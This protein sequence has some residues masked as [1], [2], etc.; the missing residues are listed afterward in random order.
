MSKK[1][2]ISDWRYI[3][4]DTSFIIDYL[5]DPDKLNLNPVKKENCI[6]AKKIMDFISSNKNRPTFYVSSIT[7][8]ELKRLETQ[9]IA[10]KIINCFSAGDVTI[11]P[12][13]KMEAEILS[14]TVF[15]WKKQKQ[16]NVTL[17]QLEEDCKKN[18]CSNFRAW[19]SDDMKIL[20]C[21]KALC[22]KGKLDVILTSDERTFL[23]IAN[24][25]GLPCAVL[26]QDN[27]PKDL[28]G[29]LAII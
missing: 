28:F 2:N 3:L 12:Y 13:G 16:P 4:L 8:G 22:S 27:F 19:I 20:S 15:E 26:K 7:I 5:S 21:V 10:K 25:M 14:N 18:G 17:K 29:E 6:L 1:W 24:F 9:S 23:P 11:L